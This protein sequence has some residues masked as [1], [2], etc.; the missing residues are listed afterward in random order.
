MYVLIKIKILNGKKKSIL[1]KN[2]KILLEMVI[3]WYLDFTPNNPIKNICNSYFYLSI[4]HG[5]YASRD[6][7]VL[8][9]SIPEIS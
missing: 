5:S 3:V 1:L 8:R 6:S 9:V 7:W 4:K 2:K